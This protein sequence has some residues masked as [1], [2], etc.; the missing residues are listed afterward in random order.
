MRSGV[1]APARVREI[2][3]SRVDGFD[4]REPAAAADTEARLPGRRPNRHLGD[5]AG[6]GQSDLFR[7]G[8]LMQVDCTARA[9]PRQG[10]WPLALDM[11]VR[12]GRALDA[13]EPFAQRDPFLDPRCQ[14]QTRRGFATLA[15]ACRF[16]ARLPQ[17]QVLY[18]LPLVFLCIHHHRRH[19]PR[20]PQARRYG[21]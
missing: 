5:G 20:P 10:T 15:R 4:R 6:E 19:R 14:P 12:F 11:V 21:G 1:R 9:E 16:R 2:E 17:H 7:C 3:R 18:P 13:A 8:Q